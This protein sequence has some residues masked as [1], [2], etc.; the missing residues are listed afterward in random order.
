MGGICCCRRWQP[1]RRVGPLSRLRRCSSE[2]PPVAPSPAT[3]AVAAVKSRRHDVLP[4]SPEWL[5]RQLDALAVVTI[6]VGLLSL[7]DD[8]WGLLHAWVGLLPLPLLTRCLLSLGAIAALLSGLC[9][10]LS[11]GSA[12]S[13]AAG[14]A[15]RGRWRLGMSE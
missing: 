7:G 5:V 2:A 13:Q 12:G 10:Q 9:G 1:K 15:Y 4:H 11:L 14:A 8:P 6:S 3:S